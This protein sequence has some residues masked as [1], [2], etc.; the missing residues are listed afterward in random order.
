VRRRGPQRS[1]DTRR[2][3]GRS[4]ALDP[5]RGE[6]RLAD[7]AA[8][9]VETRHDLRATTWARLRTTMARQ[10]LP[11]FGTTPLVKITNGAVRVWVTETLNS[12]LSAATA[13]KAVFA[14]RGCLGA[15]VADR[16]LMS[17]AAADVPLP[18]ERSKTPR[19]LSQSQVERLAA[20]IPDRYRALVLIGAYAGLRWG[21][22]IAL[23]RG[24]VDV[25]R[26][27]IL[28][29][30]TAV[31]VHGKVT[32]GNEPKTK[33][34]K[35][36]VPVARSV[37][38]RLEDHLAQHVGPGSDALLFTATNG[39]PPYRST[40][41][42]HVWHPAVSRAGLADVTFHG[43]RRSLVSVRRAEPQRLA[44]R[45]G[46]SGGTSDWYPQRDSNPRC[47]LERAVS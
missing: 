4:P 34:S 26:S 24:S 5:R 1:E 9:W 13:R 3:A 28:V 33:R 46:W 36:S 14:L 11:R 16:R 41:A 17:N 29:Q 25:I 15:A 40:F 12:G 42:R 44:Q 18:S 21:E 20:E 22:A 23:T 37:M 39:G 31:E 47:R 8:E 35:R 45:Q 10:V 38:R 2:T 32:L 7:W 6:I 19:F 27:R 30:T 43:L